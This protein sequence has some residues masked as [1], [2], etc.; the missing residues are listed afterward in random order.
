MLATT[1]SSLAQVR[2]VDLSLTGN[3]APGTLLLPGTEGRLT[4][5]L[6]NSGPDPALGAGLLSDGY[7]F[8][9]PGTQIALFPVA[10]TAPC[11]FV[12]DD[13]PPPA[14]QPGYAIV[15][16]YVGTM[17]P[18]QSVTCQLG[19]QS[20]TNA[21]GTLF[22]AFEA[23]EVSLNGVD[24]ILNNNVVGF[25]LQ[26]EVA[27]VPIHGTAGLAILAG[28]VLLVGY[29]ALQRR[30]INETRNTAQGQ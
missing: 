21:T 9:G 6:R 10:Q 25:P 27:T 4:F 23:R 3:V 18:A 20:L 12:F 29:C 5:T 1:F 17:A 14:G 19:I 8:T 15:T 24:P 16:L 13:F 26:F 2:L 7:V 22:I 30:P 28:I 11:Q